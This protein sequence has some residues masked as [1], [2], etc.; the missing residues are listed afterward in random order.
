MRGATL[1]CK[2][3]ILL[4]RRTN[5]ESIHIT[6]HR[7]LRR[8]YLTSILGNEEYGIK[9]NTDYILGMANLE[10]GVKVLLDIDRVM[11]GN[12]IAQLEQVA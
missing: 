1:N 7:G 4:W 9:L 6:V 8:K 3:L 2:Y 11:S 12:Q 5:H 10:C